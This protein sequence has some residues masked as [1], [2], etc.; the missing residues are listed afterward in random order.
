[1]EVVETAD[2]FVVVGQGITVAL[3]AVVT[4]LS[5]T[6]QEMKIYQGRVTDILECH[7]KGTGEEVIARGKEDN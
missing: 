3:D 4:R 6:G 7:R 5:E 1:M 2:F